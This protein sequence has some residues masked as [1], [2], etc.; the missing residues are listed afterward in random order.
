MIGA[1]RKNKLNLILL[2]S[3]ALVITITATLIIVLLATS[4]PIIAKEQNQ[5]D[6]V[7]IRNDEYRFEITVPKTG[8]TGKEFNLTLMKV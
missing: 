7:T 1:I 5:Q 3:L 6:S 8:L 2:K 4:S